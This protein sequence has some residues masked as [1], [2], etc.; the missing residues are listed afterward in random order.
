MANYIFPISA[1]RVL[2]LSLVIKREE[3]GKRMRKNKQYYK[4]LN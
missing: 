3:K 1:R 2:I 4:A